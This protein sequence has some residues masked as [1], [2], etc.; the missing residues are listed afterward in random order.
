MKRLLKISSITGSA[1]APIASRCGAASTRASARHGSSAVISARQPCST[2][3]VWCGSMIERR[4]LRRARR[5]P[6]P[7]AGRRPPRARRPW[8]RIASRAR[9]RRRGAARRRG[10]ARSAKRAAPPT[11]STL[12]ASIDDRLGAVDEAEARLVRALE[13]A[14]HRRRRARARPRSPCRSRR[15]ATARALDARSPRARRPGPRPRAPASSPSRST[16]G[17]SAAS[18]VV[19][20]RLLD[21]LARDARG[22]R[23]APCRR[24]RAATTADGS[25]RSSIASASATSQACWPPA[26]PKQLSA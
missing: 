24:P 3:I 10:R 8:R 20:E 25:A 11:A 14:P 5:S 21:A 18:A 7:R 26:P 16:S 6:A 22:C 23:R 12:T 4:A 9:G 2:T 15:S 17:A 13:G 19:V 1:L